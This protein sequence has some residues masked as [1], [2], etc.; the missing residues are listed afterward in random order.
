M[1]MGS[2]CSLGSMGIIWRCLSVSCC[3]IRSQA[4]RSRRCW[5]R[6][7]GLAVIT[8][9]PLMPAACFRATSAGFSLGRESWFEEAVEGSLLASDWG[10]SDAGLL[11][12]VAA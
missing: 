6:S 12:G 5:V 4:S 3:N 10:G 2:S 9:G 11:A 1:C 7:T 8:A